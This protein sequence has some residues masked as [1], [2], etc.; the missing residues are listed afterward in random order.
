MSES[1]IAVLCPRLLDSAARPDVTRLLQV[2]GGSLQVK[3]TDLLDESLRCAIASI[4]KSTGGIK[5]KF[6]DKLK[7]LEL[8]GKHMGLFDGGGSEAAESPLLEGLL[9]LSGEELEDEL[10]QAT[11]AGA[12]LVASS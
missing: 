9:R 5:V 4:E 2:E 6:Y 7:A 8:L 10:E 3:D 1:R 11:A 12:E